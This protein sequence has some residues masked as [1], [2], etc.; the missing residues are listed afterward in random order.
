MVDDHPIEMDSAR[1]PRREI[2]LVVVAVLAIATIYRYAWIPG[3]W[4]DGLLFAEDVWRLPVA[5]VGKW[6]SA[7]TIGDG[8]AFA[9]IAADPLGLDQGWE[10]SQPAFRY[11]R[12][13]F[14]WLAWV[15]SLG[16][17]RWVP[18]G[19]AIVGAAAIAA[20]FLLAVRL[21]PRLGRSAWLI[22]LNPAIFIAFAGDTAEALA[23]LALAY[24]LAT[25]RWWASAALGVIRPS[26]LIALVGRWRTLL[27]GALAAV[28]LGLLWVLRFGLDMGQYGGNFTL[29]YVGYMNAPSVQSIGL[30]ILAT[31]TLVVGLR[32]RDW[33]WVASPLLVLCFSE[34]LVADPANGW[35]AAGMLFVLW[36]F[37]PGFSAI[38]VDSVEPRSVWV[39]A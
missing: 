16:Q 32:R 34:F 2:W 15:A 28:A 7:W 17:D 36:A 35:R 27:W 23:V 37:G 30:A 9:V 11:W 4:Q 19:M 39:P 20:A 3:P 8:Q 1:A 13:G 22:V 18:Y 26:F 12:A 14:G 38:S 29:P 31:T 10:L 25:G 33:S 5:Q 6:F 21:R 24:T